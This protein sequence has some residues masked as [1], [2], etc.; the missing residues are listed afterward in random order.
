MG[1]LNFRWLMHDDLQTLRTPLNAVWG[2]CS[3]HALAH[4]DDRIALSSGEEVDGSLLSVVLGSV[5]AH[6]G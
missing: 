2:A 5:M 3:E 6:N 1:I 4:S